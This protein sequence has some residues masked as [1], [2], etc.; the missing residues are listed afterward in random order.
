LSDAA[1]RTLNVRLWLAVAAAA[2]APMDAGVMV[3]EST[4]GAVSSRMMSSV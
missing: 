4:R 3:A 1:M 2:V